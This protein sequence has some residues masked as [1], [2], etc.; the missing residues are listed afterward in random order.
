MRLRASPISEVGGA[1]NSLRVNQDDG[2]IFIPMFKFIASMVPYFKSGI[3]R[4][5]LLSQ[6][7]SHSILFLYLTVTT[8]LKVAVGEEIQ[9]VVHEM[10]IV[11]LDC[12]T[13]LTENSEKVPQSV[14]RRCF[15]V[16]IPMPN[17]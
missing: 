4:S 1:L 6:V 12:F 9:T 10:L 14:V 8:F 16:S 13:S 5:G 15:L 17:Q 2:R 3:A 7:L 11:L